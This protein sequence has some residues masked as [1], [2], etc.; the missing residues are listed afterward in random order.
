M[1]H[2][3]MYDPY[4]STKSK[5]RKGNK[6]RIQF[7]PSD[8][9]VSTCERRIEAALKKHKGRLTRSSCADVQ[10][11]LVGMVFNRD[12]ALGEDPD[13]VCIT[14][15]QALKKLRERHVVRWDEVEYGDIQLI[16]IPWEASRQP[17]PYRNF[18]GRQAALSYR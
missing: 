18:A 6:N 7:V 2:S 17:V 15:K 16:Y 4:R 14:V 10:K 9:Q 8:R 5:K 12:W 3:V 1:T 11:S 13:E